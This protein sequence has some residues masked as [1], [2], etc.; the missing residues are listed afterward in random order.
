MVH[1]QPRRRGGLLLMLAAG[2]L[3][4]CDS[5]AALTDHNHADVTPAMTATPALP[6]QGGLLQ[7]VKSATARFHATVQ[8]SR[9]GYAEA[10]PCVAAPGLGGMGFHWVNEPLV[11]PV[12]EP[13]KPEAVLYEPAGNGKLKLVAVEYIVINVG[14]PAPT[15]AGQAFDVGGTPVPVPHWSLHVWLHKENPAGIFTPFNPA[16]VCL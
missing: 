6:Q 8:A 9:A 7:D 12:F 1:S 16:V 2:I 14:Q 10:S 11:D 4:G 13:L 5:P 3:A 15:F